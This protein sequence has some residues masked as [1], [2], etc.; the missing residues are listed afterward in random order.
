MRG[1]DPHRTE[2]KS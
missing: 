1:L 2:K